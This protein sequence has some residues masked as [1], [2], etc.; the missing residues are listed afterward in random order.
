MANGG[1][2]KNMLK[3][4]PAMQ[5]AQRGPKVRNHLITRNTLCINNL[6]KHTFPV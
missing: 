2:R 6:C 3:G 1:P 4:T 5:F